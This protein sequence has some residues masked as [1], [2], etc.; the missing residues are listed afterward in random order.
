MMAPEFNARPI[1]KH[2]SRGSSYSNG[3]KAVERQ[4]SRLCI[5]LIASALLSVPGSAGAV[6]AQQPA[7][8]TT[9]EPGIVLRQTVR[10]VLVDVVVTDANGHPVEGLQASDFHIAENGKAQSIRHFE[11]HSE[12]SVDS[13]LPNRPPLPPHTFMNLP[14][15]PE[16]G[17]LTVLLYD[18]LNTP[19]DDQLNARAQMLEF[20]KRSSGRR[21]AVFVL[22]DRLHLLQG[23][24][25]DTDLLVEAVNR[26][27]G[28]S[29][30]GHHAELTGYPTSEATSPAPPNPVT[31]RDEAR[32]EGLSA[33]MTENAKEAEGSQL[34]RDRV[35]MTLDALVEIGRFLG[36][37]P[38]RKNLIWYSGSFPA[39]IFADPAKSPVNLPAGSLVRDDS[40]ANYTE[41]IKKATNLLN[42]AQVAVYP[43]DARGLPTETPFAQRSAQFASMDLIGE[44][45]G[46]RAFYNTNGLQ[47]ALESAAD[48]GSSYY[49]LVYAPINTKFDGSLRRISVHL[50]HGNY[51]LAYRRT[52]YATDLAMDTNQQ[53]S[54]DD[55][56]SESTAAASQ[57]GAPTSHQLV[58]AVH[59]DAVGAPAPATAEQMEALAPYQER[60]AKAEHKQF[61]RSTAPVSMQQYVI[62]YG[63]LAKQLVLPKSAIGVYH[64]DVSI[65]ALAFGENGTILRGTETRLK[66]DIPASKIDNI[67]QN[68]FQAVQTFSVPV[69][70]AVLRFTI[71]DEFSGRVGSMEVR[72]PL[73]A[74][75]QETGTK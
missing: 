59:V 14:E 64:S 9:Q 15:A 27:G 70:T 39:S 60:T 58:F 52:Y 75:Q 61:V 54:A 3:R 42:A 22:G 45:T 48:E 35:Q 51:H 6:A 38:G 55:E 36:G 73:T 26:I 8:I 13:A 34:L 44:E 46:G 72:L 32:W 24:T 25:S 4:C 47:Q 37:L 33:A 23:F 10:R 66:D 50:A 31:N 49:S 71:R 7:K 74:E 69:D 56:E 41:R 21:I 65:A 62:Q 28:P 11:W 63:L 17:P 40:A 19:L 20:L 16:H 1:K 57:F 53:P 68:G 12:K 2:L 67:R 29:L 5:H 18:V 30:M 43:V